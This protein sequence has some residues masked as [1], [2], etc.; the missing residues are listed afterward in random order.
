LTPIEAAEIRA[1]L[2]PMSSGEEAIDI[3]DALDGVY[4]SLVRRGLLR[5]ERQ[6][7]VETREDGDYDMVAKVYVATPLG[8]L[9]LACYVAATAGLP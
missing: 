3:E 6:H 9:A 2:G 8:R 4:E 5:W 1:N 7:W